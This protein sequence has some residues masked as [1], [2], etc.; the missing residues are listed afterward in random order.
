MFFS[1]L[2]THQELKESSADMETNLFTFMVV[3]WEIHEKR[4][5]K[6]QKL[7]HMCRVAEVC[8]QLPLSSAPSKVLHQNVAETLHFLRSPI[9]TH[10]S[11]CPSSFFFRF[12]THTHAYTHTNI[13]KHTVSM[14][15]DCGLC[16]LHTSS[17]CGLRPLGLSQTSFCDMY[18]CMCM[19]VWRCMCVCV[20]TVHLNQSCSLNFEFV[21]FNL[22]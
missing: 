11:H 16:P 2:S 20:D 21:T 13:L 19:C 9:S 6:C 1:L 10:L 15:T 7:K 22:K 18:I 14:C 4:A 12:Y 3:C 17:A 5:K 8:L